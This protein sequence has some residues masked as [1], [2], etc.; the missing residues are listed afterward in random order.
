MFGAV[1]LPGGIA[2]KMG[3]VL[4]RRQLIAWEIALVA[5]VFSAGIWLGLRSE[6][7]RR[8]PLSDSVGAKFSSGWRAPRREFVYFGSKYWISSDQFD[9]CDSG[10]DSVTPN[11]FGPREIYDPIVYDYDSSL[12]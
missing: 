11:E 3:V 6:S 9:I 12:D 2:E 1:N 10:P 8:S 4:S 7:P 5:P